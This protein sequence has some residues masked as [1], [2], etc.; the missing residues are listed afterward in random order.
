MLTFMETAILTL[1]FLVDLLHSI[2][3][4]GH[5]ICSSFT[6]LRWCFIPASS[7][8]ESSSCWGFVLN[9]LGLCFPVHIN[10]P[11][12]PLESLLWYQ[13]FQS[14]GTLLLN[15]L[16][17]LGPKAINNDDGYVTKKQ[18]YKL[19]VFA[20]VYKCEKIFFLVDNLGYLR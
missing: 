12:I 11:D 5:I 4:W 15:V 20:S 17:S 10:H 18:I 9:S 2:K 13:P 8:N 1:K 16:N 6:P 14:L 7:T 19:T 3:M